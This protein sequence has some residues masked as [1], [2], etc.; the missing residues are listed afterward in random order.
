MKFV[1]YL[2]EG[3][4]RL[5]AYIDGYL[6]NMEQLHPE[7]PQNMSMFL[8]YWDDF[9]P[10]AQGGE[11]LVKEGRI[12]REVAYEKANNAQAV[13]MMFDGIFLSSGGIV[14]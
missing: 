12:S 10:M 8:N 2:E 9:L 14:G 4:D 11:I 1:S 13:K 5:A 6:Y 3:H 7:L